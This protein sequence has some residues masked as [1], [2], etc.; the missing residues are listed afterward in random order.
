MFTGFGDINSSGDLSAGSSPIDSSGGLIAA[1][2]NYDPG[3]GFGPG[4]GSAGSAPAPGVQN[5]INAT[6]PLFGGSGSG[7]GS[8]S[9]QWFSSISN[10]A[11][12]AL[13]AAGFLFLGLI[14]AVKR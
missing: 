9:G 2:P 1:P 3:S 7:G 14:G 6:G 8:A 4:G 10:G 12:I 5:P 13:T 11:V